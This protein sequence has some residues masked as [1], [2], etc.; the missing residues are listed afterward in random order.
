MFYSCLFKK[1]KV[2]T[3]FKKG[4]KNYRSKILHFSHYSCSK[5]ESSAKHSCLQME[6]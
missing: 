2:S 6:L 3:Y 5:L 1:Q 4:L